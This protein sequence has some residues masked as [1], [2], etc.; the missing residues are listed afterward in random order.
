LYHR[1]VVE[2]ARTIPGVAAAAVASTAP[3]NPPFQ[4]SVFLEGQENA[5]TNRG[6]VVYSNI[7]GPGYFDAVRIAVL[8]GR[9]FTEADREG[10]QS[11]VIINETMARRFWPDQDALGNRFRFFGETQPR[12]IIGI[13]RTAKYVFVGEEPQSMAYTALEQGYAPDMALLVRTAGEPQPLKATIER[14]V[15][16]LD[17]D[18]ALDNIQT[19]QELL[20][21]SLTGPRVAAILLSL[22]GSVAL[23]LAAVGIYGVM[24]YSVNLRSQEIGIRMALGAERRGVLWM[25]LRQGMVTVGIGLSLGLIAAIGISRLLSGLLYGVGTGDVQAFAG[26]T[27]VLMFVAFVA[28][29]VPARRATQ[30]D[31]IKVMRYE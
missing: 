7:I 23:V 25:V 6:V 28:N 8:R 26:T 19:A 29:Y 24:S 27:F 5:D 21:A 4:R 1:Q 16:S 13:V 12:T 14:E 11:V 20:A 31:P 22:F 2:R 18:L 17:R 10:A 30:V 9:D 3:L 15:R